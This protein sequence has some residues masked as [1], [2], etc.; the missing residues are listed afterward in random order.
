MSAE[1]NIVK[2]GSKII[3]FEL[4]NPLLNK[5]QSLNELKMHKGN[6]IVFMCNHCPYVIHLLPNLVE[7]AKEYIKKGFNIIGINSNDIESYPEDSPDKMIEYISKYQIPF[8]YLF[9]ETQAV[10]H[11]YDA[12]C[13]PDIYVYNEK[14]ELVYHGR[15]DGSR[16]SNEVPVSGNELRKVLDYLL[17]NQPFDFPQLPS[18]GCSIKWK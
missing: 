5:N 2:L 14:D 12:A 10:A 9:D 4:F 17:E 16:P 3:D 8:S 18:I 11:K 13:T 15:Y 6:I 7:F 1:S